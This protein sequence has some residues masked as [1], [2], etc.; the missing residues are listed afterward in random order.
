MNA[1][2]W[3]KSRTIWVNALMGALALAES[4]L[5]MLQPLV[6]FNVY[7]ALAFGLP[8]VNLVLRTITTVPVASRDGEPWP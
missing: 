6:P 3:W 2:A 5:Q 8:I 7:G 1:K 4:Q